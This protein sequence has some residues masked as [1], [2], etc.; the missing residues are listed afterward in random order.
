MIKVLI[1]WELEEDIDRAL[2]LRE[3]IH[4]LLD[5]L[6]FWNQHDERPPKTF[7]LEIKR[8]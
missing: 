5:G 6:T 1:C 7:G 3:K 8:V 4:Q 2:E